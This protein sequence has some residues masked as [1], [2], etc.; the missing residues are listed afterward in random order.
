MIVCGLGVAMDEKVNVVEIVV[1][2]KCQTSFPHVY[3]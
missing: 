3:M 1:E 2:F